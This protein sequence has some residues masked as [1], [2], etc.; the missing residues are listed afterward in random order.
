MPL[1]SNDRVCH[2]TASYGGAHIMDADHVRT[3]CNTQR[4][5]RQ[6]AF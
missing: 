1:P 4:Q 6:G 2:P 5:R 3:G